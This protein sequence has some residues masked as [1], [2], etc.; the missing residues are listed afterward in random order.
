MGRKLALYFDG[1]WNTP[2]SD[3]NVVRL[4]RLTRSHASFRGTLLRKTF[5]K[6]PSPDAPGTGEQLKYYH[7]GVGT[8]WGSRM[9]GGMF[10]YGLSKNIRD[11]L[12]WLAAHYRPGDDI[13]L[14][15]FSRGAYTARSLGG[16][17]GRC[18]IPREP[19]PGLIDTAYRFYRDRIRDPDGSAVKAFRA[20]YTWKENDIK[21]I[22]VWDTVGALGLPLHDIWF[23]KDW[24]RFH[25]TQ[26]GG[27]VRNAFHAIALDEHRPDFAATVWTLPKEREEPLSHLEQRWFPGSH[28][29]VGGGY[30]QG[31]LYQLPLRWM[32]ER[33]AACGLEFISDAKIDDD[34]WRSPVHDSLREFAFGF[35]ALLPGIYEHFRPLH[36]GVNEQVDD[37]VKRR[38]A[39]GDCKDASGNRYDPP[40]MKM[41]E[42]HG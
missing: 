11:G 26:L 32:Q 28:A 14:F 15:G 13:Y 42:A 22:G 36:M 8:T 12:L 35:Y 24:Y 6:D 23:G 18:G 27:G 9:L 30:S 40:A 3:T 7:R 16:L 39:S 29:D 21:F 17:I 1:T 38:V 4:Y 25:D 34:A 5:T 37:T 19:I 31:K 10:G 41:P 2:G 20:T 33:A